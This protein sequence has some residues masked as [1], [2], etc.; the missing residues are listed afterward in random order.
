MRFPASLIGVVA[1]SGVVARGSLLAYVIA[2]AASC[3]PKTPPVPSARPATAPAGTSATKPT[4]S[5]APAPEPLLGHVTRAQLKA[6][7]P[8]ALFW[9]Q[10]YVP[11]ATAV[12]A[13]KRAANDVSV[14]LVMGTWC[15]DSKRELPRYFAT[16]DAAGISPALTMIGVDRTKRD[17]EGVTDKFEITRVP[18]FVFLRNGR[19]VGRFVEHTPAESTFE[20]EMARIL[21]GGFSAGSSPWRGAHVQ[22][23]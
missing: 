22:K 3:G 10:R 12:D 23:P 9:E 5:P 15:P 8:W 11:D 21:R 16:I 6:Y 19:E 13:I 20:A 14:L 1:R 2:M 4:P 17:S 18:T 7:A